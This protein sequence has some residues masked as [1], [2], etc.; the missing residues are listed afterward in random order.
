MGGVRKG[1]RGRAGAAR[2]AGLLHTDH[3]HP[4]SR[5][6]ERTLLSPTRRSRSGSQVD[7]SVLLLS[8]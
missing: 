2:A 5:G 6:W 3:K 4:C 8:S 7:Y 1:G